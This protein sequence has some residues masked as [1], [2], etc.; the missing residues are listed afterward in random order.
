[1]Q[2]K[3]KEVLVWKRGNDWIQYNPPRNHPAYE[4]WQKVK[5]KDEQKIRS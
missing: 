2:R 1:M 5:E 4:E 3:A